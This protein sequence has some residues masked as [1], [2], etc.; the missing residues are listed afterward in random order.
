MTY[1][2]RITVNVLKCFENHS[3]GILLLIMLLQ[4]NVK[5]LSK[6]LTLLLILL[7]ETSWGIFSNQR[8][9]LSSELDFFG[10]SLFTLEGNNLF[11][12][13]NAQREED[14]DLGNEIGNIYN[15]SG[16]PAIEAFDLETSLKIPDGF[17]SPDIKNF[18]E[19]YEGSALRKRL[20]FPKDFTYNFGWT[21]YSNDERREIEDPDTLELI[22]ASD[23]AFLL[24][25]KI[26]DPEREIEEIYDFI[27]L[28]SVNQSEDLNIFIDSNTAGGV[29]ERTS[30]GFV[31]IIGRP[32]VRESSGIY[33]IQF[34][35]TGLYDLSF[36][37]VDVD[38]FGDG[39]SGLAIW[40]RDFGD[41]PFE[42]P[43]D[44]TKYRFRTP[45]PFTGARYYEGEFQRLGLLRDG[46]HDGRPTIPANGDDGISSPYVFSR[47]VDDEDGVIFG[48]SWVDVIFNISRLGTHNYQLRGWSDLNRNKCF[49][50]PDHIDSTCREG[51]ELVIDDRFNFNPALHLQDPSVE[52][53]AEGLFK[54]RYYLPFN[55]KSPEL[56][57]RFRLT[58]DPLNPDVKPFG[59]FFSATD[60]DFM[61]TINC[62]S[63]GEVEDYVFPI[64]EPSTV[65]GSF[66]IGILLPLSGTIRNKRKKT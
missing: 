9:A 58:W 49:D 66:V 11:L 41:A 29:R 22:D 4:K 8:I 32:F 57:S 51:S 42:A 25:K 12:S 44:P 20:F 21:F 50:D 35:E 60:C 59:E 39:T 33:N 15:L 46:E 5:V 7:G 62:I 53:L 45:L 52:V 26:I 23:Y 61:S 43:E 28:T 1:R 16:Q 3:G 31:P 40:E 65:F 24:I 18:V 6:V 36:G 17:L 30:N 54:K 63:H 38:D 64:P 34:T 19:A 55:P 13:T 2:S 27:R 14:S 37:I 47:Q 56:Y 48:D 10:D